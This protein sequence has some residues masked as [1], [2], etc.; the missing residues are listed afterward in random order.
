MSFRY[1]LGKCLLRL[2]VLQNR[3]ITYK[4]LG[5]NILLPPPVDIG[6]RCLQLSKD[7]NYGL[8]IVNPTVVGDYHNLYVNITTRINKSCFL[9]LRD[10][11]EI[12]YNTGLAYGVTILTSANP[13][14]ELNKLYP[15]RKAPVVIGHDCW[16]GAN[17]TILPGVTIGDYSIIAAGSVVTKDV[18]SGV[19]VAGNPAK[20][21][22]ELDISKLEV[23]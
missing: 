2:P 23:Q 13:W 14:N 5:A 6:D 21:K 17:S 10:R 7:P 16:I 1:F 8:A 11:I 4:L 18:P 19:M 20:I 9:L 12:G 3:L 15:G 22:K